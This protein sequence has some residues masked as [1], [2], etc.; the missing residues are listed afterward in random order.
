[1]CVGMTRPL[2]SPRAGVATSARRTID[3]RQHRP[4]LTLA[5]AAGSGSTPAGRGRRRSASSERLSPSFQ[6]RLDERGGK[7][8]ADLADDPGYTVGLVDIVGL[9]HINR[10]FGAV[11]GNDLIRQVADRLERSG[12]AQLVARVGGDEFALLGEGVGPEDGGQWLRALRERVLR[13]PFRIEG[14]PL[15]VQF[16]LTRRAGPLSTGFDLLWVVQHDAHVEATRGLQQRLSAYERV[17]DD[18]EAALAEN[19]RLR[20]D[21]VV[22]RD[23]AN[24]DPLTGLLNRRGMHER[25]DDLDSGTDAYALCFVD[26]DDLRALNARDEL[27]EDGDAA[28][29]GVADRLREAFGDDAVARWGGDEYLAVVA[30]STASQTAATLERVLAL[31]RQELVI[32]GRPVTFSAGAAD[33][34]PGGLEP[35][36]AGA[37]RAVKEAKA[38]KATICVAE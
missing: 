11:A 16:H 2:E 30:G 28:I 23:L 36:R 9:R 15:D 25:L 19:E 31:C 26:L 21:L 3:R 20:G 6:A 17:F 13:Q 24:R 34:V 37:Q 18:A 7:A 38:R 5:A 14:I 33:C 29:A 10:D 27:W 4:G 1:M 22:L 12:F 32:S 35:G 8:W